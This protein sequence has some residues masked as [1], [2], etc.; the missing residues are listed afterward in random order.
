ML[1]IYGASVCKPLELIFSNIENVT[2]PS[3]WENCLEAS[4]FINPLRTSV[5]HDWFLYDG[6]HWSLMG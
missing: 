2:Y 6:E 4:G 1:K 5:F 3:E